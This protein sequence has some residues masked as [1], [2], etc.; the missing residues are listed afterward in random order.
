MRFGDILKQ[1]REE[2]G[3]TQKEL[4]KYINV[5]D[6][7]IG[8]YESN[9]RFPKDETILINIAKYFNVSLDY[10]VGLSIDKKSINSTKTNIS[11]EQFHNLI[12]DIKKLSPSNKV[13]L[14]DI[15]E[16]LKAKETIINLKKTK[17]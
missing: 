9:N 3:I 1:L 11:D 16:L 7:V 15:I 10:L 4:G 13:F 5:S 12:E 6:R 14:V 8:Y 17:K 2:K